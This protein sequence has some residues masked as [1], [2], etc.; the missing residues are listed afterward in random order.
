MLRGNEYI[1]KIIDGNVEKKIGRE[2]KG[3]VRYPPT[4]ELKET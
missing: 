3:N 1:N 2:R 4:R